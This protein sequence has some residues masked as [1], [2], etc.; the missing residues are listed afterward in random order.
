MKKK[1]ILF[2]VTEDWYFLSHRIK[3]AKYLIEKGYDVSV[4]CKDTGKI[5]NII[6]EGVNFYNLNIHRKSLSLYN[7]FFEI[8]SFRKVLNEVNFDIVHFISLRP[9]VVGIIASF[10]IKK[11]YFATFTGMGF[12]FIKRGL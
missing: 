11:K 6:K 10:F 4:C 7:F 9:I 1:K 12:L 5:K 8:F 3:L 2:F